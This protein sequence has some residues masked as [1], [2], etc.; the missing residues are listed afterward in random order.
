MSHEKQI[1]EKLSYRLP[2]LLPEYLKSEAPAFE[3]FLKAY[4]EF[5]EAEILT[6]ES[7]GE[8]D[9]FAIEDGTGSLLFEPATVSPSPTSETSK[10]ISETQVSLAGPYT[11]G[12]YIVGTTSKSV[13]KIEVVNGNSLFINTISGN[14]FSKG[15]TVTGRN[16]TQKGIVA[17]YKENSVLA[18]NR[19][20]DYSDIDN[21]TEDFLEYFQKDFMPSIDLASLQNSRLTIKNIHDLYQMKGTGES[22]QFLMRLLYG[23]DATI[24]YPIDE[25]IHVSESGYSQQRRLRLTMTSGIPEANDKITQ[26]D[27]TGK[28]IIAQAVIENV[29]FDNVDNLYSLEIMNN[30]VGVFTKGSTVTILDRDGITTLTATVNGIIS[31][32]TTGSSSYIAH[33]DSGVILLEDGAGLLFETKLNPFGSLYNLNDQINIVGS[34]DDT[35][36]T[37][38][39]AVVNGLIEGGITEIMIESRGSSYEAGDLIVFEGGNG[40]GAEAVIGSIVDAILLETETKP[41]GRDRIF[42]TEWEFTATASQTV[43]G[44]ASVTDDYNNLVIFNDDSVRVFVDGIEKVRTADFTTNN[45]RVTFVSGLTVG[46]TVNV[47]L[48]FNSLTYEDDSPINHET[49]TGEIRSVFIKS[50][51][52]YTTVPKAFPGGYIYLSD[53]SG[54]FVNGVVTGGTSGATAT[55]SRIETQ[56]K[57]LVVKRSSTDTGVFQVGELIESGDTERACTQVNVSSGTGAKLFVWSDT[58]GGVA[59]INIQDQGNKFDGDGILSSTSHFPMLITTPSASLTRDLTFTGDMSGSTGKVVSYDADRHILTYSN[60]TGEFF[61]NEPVSFNISDS[62][63]VLKSSIFDGRGLFAGEG[64]IEE[65]IVGDY[66]TTNAYASRIHD[67]KFYQSHSYVVKVGESINKWRGVVKDLLHPAG[68]IFFGEVAIKNLISTV[69]DSQVRFLP[70]IMIPLTTDVSITDAFSNSVKKVQIYTL[71]HED[72]LMETGDGIRTE[73]GFGLLVTENGARD[74]QPALLALREAGYAAPNTNPVDG[75]AIPAYAV[76]GGI[77]TGKG[78]EYYDSEMRSRKLNI[79]V[80]NS[81]ASAITQSSP[82]LDS[83]M[84]VLNLRNIDNGW[85]VV[86]DERNRYGRPADQGKTHVVY[87]PS[88]AETLVYEDGTIILREPQPDYLRFEERVRRNVTVQG[89]SGERIISED[90]NDLFNLETATTIEPVEHFVTERSIE[91]ESGLFLEDGLGERL[92]SEDGTA[93]IQEGVSETGLTSFVPFGSTLRTLNIITGQQTYD[94]SY[95]V[96]D[97]S[98]DGVM[99]E[100]GSGNVLSENSKPEGLRINDLD[101]YFPNL[102][103]PEYELQARKRTNITFSAYIKSA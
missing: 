90:G 7:Q 62:F 11:V 92:I 17:T 18:N 29:Y 42:V 101:A 56:Q 58:A 16:S 80:I 85:V 5:L 70:T 35:D 95:Y 38:S 50:G 3:A 78:T 74:L 22:L 103:L 21:T 40:D 44:G 27:S 88:Q 37:E 51:G 99:L 94:I 30:H 32:I 52:S 71:D 53:L 89:V 77:E 14:G 60:L 47:Y 36:T 33:N 39:L 6:L 102:H 49:A 26:Y 67:G 86:E 93:F 20:L 72:L 15:E 81:V 46:Q 79:T 100:T 76:V 57:R 45:D 48:S 13:A 54:Y 73:D 64:I 69:A 96:K 31:D 91:V 1:S 19:L 43:F 59:S 66:G 28:I 12:E 55:I 65:Q 24:R 10:V 41:E 83:V 61:Q 9:G 75:G 2:S 23:Q 63:K 97:E 87:T 82:R 98:D 34:K 4:F 68:H 84:S 8:L 25:T